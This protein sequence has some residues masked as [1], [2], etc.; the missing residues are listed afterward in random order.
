MVGRRKFN[1]KGHCVNDQVYCREC[2]S[3]WWWD[4]IIACNWEIHQTYSFQVSS[5]ML[6]RV[7]FTTSIWT[8]Y[9]IM[10]IY[11]TFKYCN[12]LC[13]CVI[14]TL[15]QWLGCCG[16]WVVIPTKT[17]K[18]SCNHIKRLCNVLTASCW[19]RVILVRLLPI[20]FKAH[21]LNGFPHT[22]YGEFFKLL[23]LP[24]CWSHW[25]TFFNG[26]RSLSGFMALY[27][28]HHRVLEIQH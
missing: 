27:F 25:S 13:I 8:F 23:Y 9:I 22:M 14:C 24:G 1:L 4:N 10:Y 3:W 7:L 15:E 12:R 28:S 6:N 21:C 11:L 5:H 20:N 16:G 19:V 18:L 26:F 17:I 2:S